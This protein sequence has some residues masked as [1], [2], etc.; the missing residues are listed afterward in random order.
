[1]L[2]FIS[3]MANRLCLISM[4]HLTELSSPWGCLLCNSSVSPPQEC[5]MAKWTWGQ[6][7][8]PNRFFI[9]K[10]QGNP[11]C[12][13]S[14]HGHHAPA[15]FC[16]CHDSAAVVSCAEILSV[17]VFRIKVR[18]KWICHQIWKAINSLAPGR[19]GWHLKTAMFNLVLLIDTFTLSNDNA[20]RW[21]P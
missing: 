18:A 12:G 9:I 3:I 11:F 20:L 21:M 1:M 19:P 4:S 14:I 17:R 2:S 5:H 6:F 8:E 10:I 7:Q 13:N 16:T 15:K